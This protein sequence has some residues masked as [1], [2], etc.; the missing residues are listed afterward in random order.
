[1]TRL[2]EIL[3]AY[4]DVDEAVGEALDRVAEEAQTLGRKG[5]VTV[6]ITAE[7]QGRHVVIDVGHKEKRPDPDREM[8]LWHIGPTGLTQDDRTQGRITEDGEYIA[9]DQI[10]KD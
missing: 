2:S 7:K 10:R 6:S 8:H 9:P 1:M 5:A 4:P 3:A